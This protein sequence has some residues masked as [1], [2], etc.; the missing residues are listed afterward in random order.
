MA[1]NS[2]VRNHEAPQ[3]ALKQRKLLYTPADVI[4]APQTRPVGSSSVSF[5]AGVVDAAALGQR[6]RSLGVSRPW[7]D[8]YAPADERVDVPEGRFPGRR[9]LQS[10]TTPATATVTISNV[11]FD[12]HGR[13]SSAPEAGV[14]SVT[15]TTTSDGQVHQTVLISLSPREFLKLK[16]ESKMFSKLKKRL[17]PHCLFVSCFHKTAF[18]GGKYASIIRME[19]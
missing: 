7:A 16:K 6:A 13:P 1:L 11:Q 9:Q 4:V 15:I 5:P 3:E 2:V 18:F 14:T 17:S 12:V 10:V 19:D 8:S